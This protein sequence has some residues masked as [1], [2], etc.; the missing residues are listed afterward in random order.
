MS[1]EMSF[2]DINRTAVAM[3]FFDINRTAVA[4]PFV[5]V[6]MGTNC[7]TTGGASLGSSDGRL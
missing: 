6:N 2:V 3:P 4:I 1:S 7:F 5:D